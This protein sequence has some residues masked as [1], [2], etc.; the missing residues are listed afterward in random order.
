MRG[1]LRSGGRAK[2]PPAIRRS[3]D[4]GW[5]GSGQIGHELD[6]PLHDL[7]IRTHS[8]LVASLRPPSD[9][10]DR[11]ENLHN[12]ATVTQVF[13]ATYGAKFP[14]AVSTIVDDVDAACGLL[15][16]VALLSDRRHLRSVFA[17]R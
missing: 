14:E 16:L 7:R 4:E 3:N 8:S 1:G 12:T 15:V 5:Q 11:V 17:G 10:W 9:L 6:P 13:T 2:A